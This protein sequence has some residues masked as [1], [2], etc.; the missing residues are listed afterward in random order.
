M[1]FCYPGAPTTLTSCGWMLGHRLSLSILTKRTYPSPSCATLPS[2]LVSAGLVHGRSLTS[3]HSLQHDLRNAGGRWLDR[4]V[5]VDRNWVSSRDP[6]DLPAFNRSMVQMFSIHQP[7]FD[8]EVERRRQLRKPSRSGFHILNT[9][10][11][12]HQ[13]V[14]FFQQ[15]RI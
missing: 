5:V 15:F 1:P 9:P 10:P 2:L 8:I 4:E 7:E 12:S 14:Y 13:G 11:G 6:D 3:Y